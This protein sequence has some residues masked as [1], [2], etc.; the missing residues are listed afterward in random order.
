[1]SSNTIYVRVSK[2]KFRLKNID[3]GQE[4]TAEPLSPFTTSRLLIGQFDVAEKTL[5]HAFTSIVSRGLFASSPRVVMH[6]LEMVEGGLAEVEER[7]MR[8]LAIGAASAQKVVVWTGHELS[9]AEI[10]GKL[11]GE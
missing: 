6:P 10:K 9:D 4:Q 3:S 5:K 1:V 8:E 7:V 2:N 11:N